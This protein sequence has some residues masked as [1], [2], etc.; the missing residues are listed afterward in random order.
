MKLKRNRNETE[1]KQFQNCLVSA[2]SAVKR[3]SCFIQS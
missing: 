3:F 1:T 2:K